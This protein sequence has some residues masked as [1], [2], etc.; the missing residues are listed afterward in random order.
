MRIVVELLQNKL[1][2]TNY[3]FL[4][5]KLLEIETISID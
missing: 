1:L 5:F 2:I 3:F 4:F